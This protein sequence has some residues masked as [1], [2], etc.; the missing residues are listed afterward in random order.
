MAEQNNKSPH[1]LN[2]SATLMGLCFVVLTSFSINNMAEKSII[3]ELTA[4]AIFMFMASCV[5]SFL[6]MRSIKKSG[7][8]FEQ[9]AD[10]I[11]LAG[12]FFLFITTSLI[13][14]NII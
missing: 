12:L 2:T 9:I 5:L 1:I 4:M 10:L 13:V 14:F 7:I 8:R 11:F 6:S 3:D